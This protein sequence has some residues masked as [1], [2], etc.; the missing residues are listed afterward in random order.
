MVFPA[1]FFKTVRPYII[2]VALISSLVTLLY[3]Y[4][5]AFLAAYSKT[6]F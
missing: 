1:A 2:N 3:F 6:K 4:T 5:V